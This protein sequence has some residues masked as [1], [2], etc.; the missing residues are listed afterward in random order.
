[1]IIKTSRFGEIEI[2]EE[3]CFEMVHPLLGYEDERKFVL[4]EHAEHSSFRWLQSLK[5]PELAF[6]VSIAGLFGIDYS[7]ELP[8]S[9][10]DDLGIESVDDILALNIVVIPHANP[11]ASTINL[12][13][14]L[15]FNI[16]NKKG[17]QVIL[18]GSNFKVD[19]PLFEKEAVC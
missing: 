6:A 10:Q 17:A 8:E 11:R 9:T 15:I 4:V 18:T 19:Y 16:N 5:T 13:A 14:P 2:D 7:F 1:M 12:L 3:S